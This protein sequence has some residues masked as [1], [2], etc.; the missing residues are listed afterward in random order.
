MNREKLVFLDTET[1]GKEKKDRLCQVAYK[2][3]GEEKESLFKPPIPIEI[4]AMAVSHITNQMVEDKEAFIDSQM[5]KELKKIFADENI[6]VAHNALFDADMLERENLKIGKMIDTYKIA[7]Y[8]DVEGEIPRY[9]LQYL[10]YYFD[11]NVTDAPAHNALG[12][13]RVLEK[14]FDNFFEK[15]MLEFGDE[16]RVIEKMIEITEN[17]ILIKKFSFGKYNG[18][19]ISN[20]FQFDA[21][22]L[23]WLLDEKIKSREKGE[24]DDKDWIYTLEYYLKR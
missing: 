13:I 23:R 4:E 6:L 22:Y 9:A 16:K 24:G 18:E 12:D 11:L 17:P 5:Q 7:Q 20:V 21:R 14:L 1:T 19:R 3:K 10:R 15:M 2:F 8:L